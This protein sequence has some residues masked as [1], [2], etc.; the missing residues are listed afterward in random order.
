LTADPLCVLYVFMSDA[1]STAKPAAPSGP[2]GRTRSAGLLALVRAI[3]DYGRTL[4]GALQRQDPPAAP[5]EVAW[6]YGTASL[7]VIIGR[8]MRGLRIAEALEARLI[9]GARRLDAADH[10]CINDRVTNRGTDNGPTDR[11]RA[12][13]PPSPPRPPRWPSDDDADA[14][15]D[16]PSAQEI[17]RRLRNRS[18][19]N[20]IVDI[21]LDL[22]IDPSHPLWTAVR[23]ALMH[24][25][26]NF[27][28]LVLEPV[29]RSFGKGLLPPGPIDPDGLMNWLRRTAAEAVGDAAPRGDG[30]RVRAGTGPPLPAAA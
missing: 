6:R 7:A 27:P 1:P 12:P 30:G 5:A 23:H 24:E 13:R 21:C 17:A 8:V 3:I 10:A 2:Q 20:V 4:A 28:R 11:S 19:G 15:R 16:L 14:L 9:R 29:R 25:G 22:C 18:I 26:G